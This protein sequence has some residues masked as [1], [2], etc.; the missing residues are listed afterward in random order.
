MGIAEDVVAEFSRNNVAGKEITISM[1]IWSDTK[2]FRING[3]LHYFIEG[4]TAQNFHS[5]QYVFNISEVN[6]WERYTFT[7]KLHDKYDVT[8]VARL[9]IYGG[10]GIEGVA[11]V[12]NVKLELAN[13]AT[14]WTPA[15]EDQVTTDEFNKNNRDRKSV[16]G[17]TTSVSTVQKIK[18][19]C[20]Q[21]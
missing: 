5:G 19:Q 17:V 16:E 11:Y 4:N 2:G 6:R 14:A 10:E 8:K 1:D 13:I 20:N 9:Y 12:K 3:G 7:M 21:L 15:P 18:G